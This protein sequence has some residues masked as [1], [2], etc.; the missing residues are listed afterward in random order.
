ML[1]QRS[2]VR[3][4]AL[5]R[6]LPPLQQWLARFRYQPGASK[7]ARCFSA[8]FRGRHPQPK[9]AQNAAIVPLHPGQ[10]HRSRSPGPLPGSWTI[11]RHVARQQQLP[12][13]Q[14]HHPSPTVLPLDIAQLRLAPAQQILG[15]GMPGLFAPAHAIVGRNQRPVQPT[16]HPQ[17]QPLGVLRLPIDAARASARPAPA[18]LG[19]PAAANRP[20]RA[21]PPVP[22]GAS[23]PARSRRGPAM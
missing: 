4:G 12:R 7:P 15:L 6:F 13:G 8:R 20:S 16:D 9:L 19:C 17:P 1:H 18:P 11:L 14:Q 23:S 3:S 10:R 5:G 22:H 2:L 21:V